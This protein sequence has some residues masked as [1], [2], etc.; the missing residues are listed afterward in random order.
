M[1]RAKKELIIESKSNEKENW[2][3]LKP[4][5]YLMS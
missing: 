2:L 3:D 1:F 4:F 5:Y